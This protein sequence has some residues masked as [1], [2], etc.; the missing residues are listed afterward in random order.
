MLELLAEPALLLPWLWQ[1][2]TPDLI[3]YLRQ[4]SLLTSVLE[5]FEAVSCSCTSLL[6]SR[7][8]SWPP[9]SHTVKEM[10][11]YSTVSTLNP[12]CKDTH[13]APRAQRASNQDAKQGKTGAHSWDGG[14]NLSAAHQEGSEAVAAESEP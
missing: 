10:F 7:T 1:W 11:L 8:L 9:T 5:L 4:G 12:I 14:H 13:S 2:A 3:L 6:G